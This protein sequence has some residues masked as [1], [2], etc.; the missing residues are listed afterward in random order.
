MLVEQRTYELKPGSL[1]EFLRAYEAEG[2]AIQRAALGNLLGYFVTEVGALNRV[3][4]LWGYESF[5][6]RLQ[7]RAQLGANAD[8]RAFASRN[9]ALIVSQH[10]QLLVPASFSPIK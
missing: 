8:W 2:L 5:E 6:D 10:S 4:Q 7:R 1:N 9:G 3:V